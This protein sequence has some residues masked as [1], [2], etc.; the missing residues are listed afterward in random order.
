MKY[1]CIKHKNNNR[2]INKLDNNNNNNRNKHNC[3]RQKADF[4]CLKLKELAKNYC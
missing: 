1:Y 4:Y 2:R 3:R